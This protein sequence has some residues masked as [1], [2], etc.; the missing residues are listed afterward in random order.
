MAFHGLPWPSM[1]SR[2]F[3]FL[4]SRLRSLPVRSTQ[5]APSCSP[6]A[7][8]NSHARIWRSAHSP[9]LTCSARCSPRA[10]ARPSRRPDN[11]GPTPRRRCGTIALS[12]PP[13]T[14]HRPPPTARRETHVALSSTRLR[15]PRRHPQSL[16]PL[17]RCARCRSTK[18]EA[19]QTEL[20]QAGLPGTVS[21]QLAMLLACGVLASP[22]CL[23]VHSHLAHT[24]SPHCR[25]THM[26]KQTALGC[27]NLS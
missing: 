13:P 23:Q 22:P 7:L 15:A 25:R 16:S 8:D 11:Y 2:A 12:S 10:R 21:E 6:S 20:T 19:L 1:T 14:A 26:K 9:F 24:S 27:L 18:M 17:A 4:S 3:V 5:P